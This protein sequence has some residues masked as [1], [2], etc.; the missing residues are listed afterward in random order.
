LKSLLYEEYQGSGQFR[1]RGWARIL[2]IGARQI[3]ADAV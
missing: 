3:I 1:P 2:P